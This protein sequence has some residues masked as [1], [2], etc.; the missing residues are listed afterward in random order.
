[1]VSTAAPSQIF[2]QSMFDKLSGRYDLFNRLTSLGLD[3]LW[4]K[5]AVSQLKPGT[6]ILDLGCGTGDLSLAAAHKMGYGEITALD[7]S[8]QMLSVAE[9][10]TAK[11]KYPGIL[12]RFERRKAEEIPFED[13]PY[14]AVISGFVL[15]NIYENIDNILDGVYR[16]LKPGGKLAL[17]DF[18]E[19]TNEAFR[20]T[21][22]LYMDNVAAFYGRALFGKDFPEGYLTA[23]AHRFPKAKEFVTK[24]RQ[25][26]F[27]EVTAESMM[28][29]CIVLYRAE[30]K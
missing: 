11:K 30:R 28:M 10:R 6:R 19:P 8:S 26:G 9:K 3:G 18:T 12:F 29:G 25:A 15:R 13:R 1:M 14:D 2:I 7:F 27:K 4:R 21:W 17:L 24:L 16:A 22:R 23:S 20:K 5:K